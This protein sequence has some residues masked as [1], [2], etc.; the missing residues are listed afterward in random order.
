MDKLIFSKYSNERSKKLQIRTDILLSEDG[1]K[2]IV[3]RAASEEAVSHIDHMYSVYEKLSEI[4]DKNNIGVNV[5]HRLDEASVEFEY[6]SGKTY[7]EILDEEL[8]RKNYLKII[9]LIR[10]YKSKLIDVLPTTSFAV[11]KEFKEVFGDIDVGKRLDATDIANID[12]VFCNVVI[13]DRWNILDYE[14][15]YDFPVPI[16]FI[17]YRAIC[18][19]LYSSGKRTEIWHLG[20]LQLF[21]IDEE[22]Q[23]IY[24]AMDE[25]F[26]KWVQKGMVSI[27]ELYSDYNRANYEIKELLVDYIPGRVQVFYDEGSSWTE[28]NS[29][30]INANKE[31]EDYVLKI[32]NHKNLKALRIDPSDRYCIVKLYEVIAVYKDGNRQDIEFYNNGVLVAD[33]LYIYN[34]DDP[35]WVIP[36]MDEEVDY[37]E[38]KYAITNISEHMADICSSEASSYK[39]ELT[40]TKEELTSTKEELTIIGDELAVTKEQLYNTKAVVDELS[41]SCKTIGNER[42][43]LNKLVDDMQKSL[44]WKVTKPIRAV[45][46]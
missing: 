8:E 31:K 4:Y 19:Y 38:I 12:M 11:T 25:S 32:Y 22:E 1:Q 18:H 23:K 14:W 10:D 39:E 33:K 24:K 28:D 9:D 5:C 41:K 27:G 17:L 20:F 37:I 26:H 42:D 43:Y 35:Q 30:F 16:N 15:T 3:K 21:G 40:S 36:N 2:H 45:K 6:V 7:E 29:E 34:T 13:N 46:K 44:S